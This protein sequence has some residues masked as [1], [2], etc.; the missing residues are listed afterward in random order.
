MFCCSWAIIQ[1][2]KLFARSSS[3]DSTIGAAARQLSGQ[4]LTSVAI[5]SKRGRSRFKFDFGGVLE[6]RRAD[7]TGEQWILHDPSKHVL[8]IH[9]DGRFSYDHE[10]V[11]CGDRERKP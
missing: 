5:D 9:A 1:D 10:S 2:G 6:T 8:Q 11:R 7:K 3:R 4:A